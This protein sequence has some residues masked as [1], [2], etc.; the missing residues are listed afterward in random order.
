[1]NNGAAISTEAEAS[2]ANGGNIMLKVRDFLYLVSSKITT[3]VKG[4]TG[5][6]G[7][8]AIDPQFV[9]L[10]HSSITAE[11][12]EGHGGNIIINAGEYIA[13]TDSI[14][15]AT[16]QKGISGTV[17]IGGPRVDVNGA[18]VVLS[19]D[20]AALPKCSGT[21]AL[22]RLPNRNRAW[23]R[24]VGAACRRIRRRR[25]PLSISSAVMSTPTLRPPPA[26]PKRRAH[27]N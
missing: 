24:R 2:T 1:M 9:V 6:G 5:N 22:R 27:Y 18:L 19:S 12:I 23:S 26:H 3:S 15:S 11:A 10:N 4:E 21:A 17:E 20:C 14:V 8:I 25:F 7:N 16:S 13:S